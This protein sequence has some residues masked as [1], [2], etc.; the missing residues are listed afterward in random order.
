MCTNCV[1]GT[2]AL[3]INSAGLV[4]LGQG[5]WHRLTDRLRGRPAVERR[6][7]AWEA[8]AAFVRDLGLDPLEVLGAPPLVPADAELAEHAIR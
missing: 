7:R 8:N 2:E 4:A 1:T 5:G 3:L 6:Q